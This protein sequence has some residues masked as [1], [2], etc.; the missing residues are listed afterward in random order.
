MRRLRRH[1]GRAV[2]YFINYFPAVLGALAGDAVVERSFIEAFQ[3]FTKTSL[4]RVDQRVEAAVA[5][6][7]L[8]EILET[9]FGAPLFFVENEYFQEDGRAVLV[10][11]M[12]YRGDAYVYTASIP[13]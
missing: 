3:H 8:A 2:S 7:G 11:H 1:Q 4:V 10:T 5:D 6:M 13:L 9:D 12:Y